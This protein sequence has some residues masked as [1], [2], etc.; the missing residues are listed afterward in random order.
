[1]NSPNVKKPYSLVKPQVKPQVKPPNII[2]YYYPCDNKQLIN[3][4]N[5]DEYLT[6]IKENTY[7]YITKL[8]DTYTNIVTN[9]EW[10]FSNFIFFYFI[11]ELNKIR[12]KYHFTYQNDRT[13]LDVTKLPNIKLDI[14]TLVEKIIINDID[15]ILDI[16]ISAEYYEIIFLINKINDLSID[17]TFPD[18][19]IFSDLDKI[20]D[21]IHDG[22]AYFTLYKEKYNKDIEYHNI[23]NLYDTN[24]KDIKT[25]IET[26]TTK[27]NANIKLGDD[28]INFIIT[29][30]RIIM[31]QF[32]DYNKMTTCHELIINEITYYPNKYGDDAFAYVIYTCLPEINRLINFLKTV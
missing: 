4:D 18:E 23:I 20:C 10:L 28:S 24:I 6:L 1:M 30:N 22:W 15:T 7:N 32:L 29:P 16:K 12:E 5:I 2:D 17:N 8:L 26:N 27:E 13:N 3:N 31:G 21:I 25:I 11:S 14:S 9:N 19:I